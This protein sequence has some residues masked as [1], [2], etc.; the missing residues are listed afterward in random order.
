MD[1]AANIPSR[2][3]VEIS[4]QYYERETWACFNV[5]THTQENGYQYWDFLAPVNTPKNSAFVKSAMDVWAAMAT[6]PSS[7]RS[8]HF[9]SDGGAHIKNAVVLMS[10]ISVARGLGRDCE[11][12]YFASYHGK[13]Q[14]DR[15]FGAISR[16]RKRASFDILSIRDVAMLIN[17]TLHNSVAVDHSSGPREPPQLD[18]KIQ[19]MRSLFQVTPMPGDDLLLRRRPM[20]RG[21]VMVAPTFAL[22]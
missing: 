20:E 7:V 2:R 3:R 15:H 17:T 16:A 10:S 5:T 12:F 6:I 18:R 1:F 8:L 13:S 9:W 11:V 14:C 19:G 21:D 4:A 22:N